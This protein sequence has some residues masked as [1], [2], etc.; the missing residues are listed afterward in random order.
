[1]CGP[2]DKVMAAVRQER[3]MYHL[4]GTFLTSLIKWKFTKHSLHICTDITLMTAVYINT[5][6]HTMQ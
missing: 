6:Y 2:C 5:E 4:I 3:H 1:M